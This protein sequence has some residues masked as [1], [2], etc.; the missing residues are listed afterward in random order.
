M[1]CS[2]SKTN[3]LAIHVHHF[4]HFETGDIVPF[5]GRFASM[6]SGQKIVLAFVLADCVFETL[7]LGQKV[8]FSCNMQS[9]DKA[10]F[11]NLLTLPLSENL[12]GH[13][14]SH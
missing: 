5:N 12:P 9:I 13:G 14:K 6:L 3:F 8:F 11:E 7:W 1:N 4:Q 2:H 10:T